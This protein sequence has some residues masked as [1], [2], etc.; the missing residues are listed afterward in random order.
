MGDL[1]MN[2]KNQKL[3]EL[4]EELELCN[5]ISEPTSFKGISHICTNI[6]LTNQTCFMK[7]ITFQTGLSENLIRYFTVAI[8]AL[9]IKKLKKNQKCN[10][11]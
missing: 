9:T 6:F 8:K 5:L 7:P 10:Y 2:P 11:F 1:I 3:N 4:I